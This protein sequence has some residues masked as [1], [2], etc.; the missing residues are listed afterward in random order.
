MNQFL[1]VVDENT[2]I[3]D[4]GLTIVNNTEENE[5]KA[6]RVLPVEPESVQISD[7][8]K[9]NSQMKLEVPGNKTTRKSKRLTRARP[10]KKVKQKLKTKLNARKK[11]KTEV[12]ESDVSQL[13]DDIADDNI[14]VYDSDGTVDLNESEDDKCNAPSEC[15]LFMDHEKFAGFPKVIIENSKLIFRG[16]KL[17]DLLSRWE[18]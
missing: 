12:F 15:D 7:A 18:L 13:K 3:Q 10:T 6:A 16:K 17:L 2:P 8:S 5:D 1:P 11:I 9:Q 14:D 4:L